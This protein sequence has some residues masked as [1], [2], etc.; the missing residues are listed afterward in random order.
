MNTIVSLKIYSTSSIIT[1]NLNKKAPPGKKV[2][3]GFVFLSFK[4][5]WGHSEDPHE[6]SPS[7]LLSPYA[8]QKD[9]PIFARKTSS[10]SWSL[11]VNPVCFSHNRS[12]RVNSNWGPRGL[13]SNVSFI[14]A[15]KKPIIAWSSKV[16]ADQGGKTWQQNFRPLQNSHKDLP[17]Y[18]SS[19]TTSK[20]IKSHDMQ[21]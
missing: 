10:C 21:C 17:F 9:G 1:L 13:N 6:L 4:A 14:S 5:N 7:S 8:Y 2:Q 3:S 11:K 19:K 20:P 12:T 18:L 15:S 16:R